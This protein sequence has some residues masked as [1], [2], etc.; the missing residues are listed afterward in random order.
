MRTRARSERNDSGLRR[1][2]FESKVRGGSLPGQVSEAKGCEQ[3][4]YRD[5]DQADTIGV[6]APRSIRLL[7]PLCLFTFSNC[8]SDNQAATNSVSETGETD[9]TSEGISIHQR[10]LDNAEAMLRNA[11]ICE[12]NLVAQNIAACE[13]ACTLNHS[14]SC[15]NWGTLLSDISP[16][17]AIQ[18][19][20]KAC[21]GGSG[22][23]CESRA[24]T[25]SG[26]QQ[27]RFFHHARYYH[28]VH[29]NQGYGRSCLQ[30]ATLFR[31]GLG[32]GSD[33][34]AAAEFQ[35]RACLLG[36]QSECN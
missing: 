19:F 2:G 35:K 28:R 36:I 15:A 24:R 1:L 25:T 18:L 31:D 26:R 11:A 3:R 14:N 30:L 5:C 32:G 23:G 20:E 17:Q 33:L 9:K 10:G 6:F 22:I 8:S 21:K 12:P 7:L 13:T 27:V 29:C 34:A 4:S 16:S